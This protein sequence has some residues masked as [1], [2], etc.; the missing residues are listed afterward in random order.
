MY[1]AT[2][3]RLAPDAVG[4]IDFSSYRNRQSDTRPV[5]QREPRAAR[6]TTKPTRD[7]R[8]FLGKWLNLCDRLQDF[9]GGIM[10]IFS[11]L[12]EF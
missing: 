6:P 5:A 4:C 1:L 7:S 12:V 10:Y 3:I 9:C 2:H 11:P 8:V